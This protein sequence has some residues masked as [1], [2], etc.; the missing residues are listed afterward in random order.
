[1]SKLSIGPAG[2]ALNVPAD[3]SHLKQAIELE[4]LG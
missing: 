3:D 2:I 1:M 4:E